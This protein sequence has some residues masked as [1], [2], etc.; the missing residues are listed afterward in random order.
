[1]N[2]TAATSGKEAVDI[3]MR[4]AYEFVIIDSVLPDIDGQD[5]ARKIKLGVRSN[6]FIII[7]SPIGSMVQRYEFVSG[8]LNKPVKPLLL[9]NLLINLQM[10]QKGEMANVINSQRE[11]ATPAKDHLLAILLAEDNP[12]NQKVAL[13]MLKRLGYKADVA[14]NGFEVLK[15]LEVRAYD[16]I[17][18]DIQ[19]PEMD[20]LDVTRCIRKRKEITEQPCIIAMTAYALEGDRQECLDAGMNEYLRKPIQIGELKLALEM[21]SRGGKVKSS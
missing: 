16:V 1:M 11:I 8:W 6:A 7:M 18:M 21:C 12:V 5:L 15:S 10:P 14:A 9:R 20:G 3:L 17:L 4:E 19:M 13:S 2:V